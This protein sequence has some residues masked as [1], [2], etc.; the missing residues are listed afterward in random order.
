MRVQHP[1]HTSD[2]MGGAGGTP[3][4]ASSV[5]GNGSID[6]FVLEPGAYQVYFWHPG[7][8]QG[9]GPSDDPDD[10]TTAAVGYRLIVERG[11][12]P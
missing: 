2:G 4:Y 3:V 11:H 6:L 12:R 9:P 7:A 8:V 5:G 1:L 10:H